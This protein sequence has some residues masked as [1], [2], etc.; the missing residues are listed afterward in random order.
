[1]FYLFERHPFLRRV[2]DWQPRTGQRQL[3]FGVIAKNSAAPWNYVPVILWLIVRAGS[4]GNTRA[5][6]GNRSDHVLS[7]I[8]SRDAR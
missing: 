4:D 7:R 1:M 2:R 5:R 8:D 3:L 6:Y